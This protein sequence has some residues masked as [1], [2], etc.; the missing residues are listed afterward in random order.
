MFLTNGGKLPDYTRPDAS[1]YS[2]L[3][4]GHGDGTF[5]EV[6]AKA[7]VEGRNLDISYG[8]ARSATPLSTT[9]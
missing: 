3:L 1:Y 4:R 7:K 8:V 5:E 9:R 2:C 6:T